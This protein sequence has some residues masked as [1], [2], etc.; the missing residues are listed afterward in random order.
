MKKKQTESVQ[1]KIFNLQDYKANNY[2]PPKPFLKWAGG[3]TQLLNKIQEHYP[4][5][6][7]AGLITNYCEPFLGGGAVFFD[8]MQKYKIERAFLYDINEELILVYKVIKKDVDKLIYFLKKYKDEYIKLNESERKK[9]YYNIRS[10]Y[11]SHR[12]DINHKVFSENWIPRAAQM[13]FLNRTCFNGLYRLN[14]IG[15]FNV[16]MGSYTNPKILDEQ[17]LRSVSNILQKTIIEIA[18]F[19]SLKY[20]VTPQ[21]F[22][23]VDPPFRPISK[24]ASFTSYSKKD[25]NDDEQRRLA[26]LFID[27]DRIGCKLMLSNSDP[28]NIK[29]DDNFFDDLYKDFNIYRVQARRIINSV[30][31]KRGEINELIIAN[32]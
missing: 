22:I 7:K 2:T 13:L 8:V 23:Y 17:N 29:V 6:L 31:S 5:E 18:D 4:I 12:L 15:E 16:P 32:Y 9:Y 3:K 21:T 19:E 24:T 26:N 28:K 30:A 1:E 14:S 10:I 27:L 20:T 25:F 11:N